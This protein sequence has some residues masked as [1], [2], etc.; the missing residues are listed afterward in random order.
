MPNAY[1]TLILQTKVAN[2]TS[3]LLRSRDAKEMQL[4]LSC[5]EFSCA[6]SH[7]T[8]LWFIL[9]QEIYTP[10]SALGI[11]ICPFATQGLTSE[12]IVD[13]H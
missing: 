9:K 2:M 6:P 13:I 11:S 8:Y 7:K 10:K 1:F 5:R 3:C 12:R 4:T